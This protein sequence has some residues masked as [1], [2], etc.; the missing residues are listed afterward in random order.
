[1]HQG[2]VKPLAHSEDDVDWIS[3]DLA[4]KYDESFAQVSL[5]QLIYGDAPTIWK[6]R[7]QTFIESFAWSCQ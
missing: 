5:T 4:S 3:L 2:Y 6:S 1:M 7:K